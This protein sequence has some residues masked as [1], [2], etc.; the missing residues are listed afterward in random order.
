MDGALSNYIK[1]K[2]MEN[3]DFNMNQKINSIWFNIYLIFILFYSFSM[4]KLK[5]L[6]I[7]G[8]GSAIALGEVGAF[9]MIKHPLSEEFGFKESALGFFLLTQ[10]YLTHWDS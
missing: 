5:M 8:I 3:I 6:F 9:A 7:T 4:S 10:V 2:I 1:E